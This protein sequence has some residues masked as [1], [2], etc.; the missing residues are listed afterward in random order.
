MPLRMLAVPGDLSEQEASVWSRIAATKPGGWWDAGNTG[1]LA[2]YCR[3][4]VQSV[5]VAELV[6]RVLDNL[7]HDPDEL[8]RY[9]ELRKIQGGLSGEMASLAT[10]MRL[11]Q[12]SSY[13]EKS[14]TTA[15]AKAVGR[16]PW[17]LD[18]LEG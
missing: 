9:K 1:L 8:G 13:T 12:Q 5:M 7:A 4:E 3:A 16:K 2:Q 18:V 15:K 6:R 14:A 11:S 10:K 17:A